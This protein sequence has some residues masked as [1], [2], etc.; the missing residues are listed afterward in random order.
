M[1]VPQPWGHIPAAAGAGGGHVGVSPRYTHCTMLGYSHN[2]K[3]FI[4][5]LVLS[6]LLVPANSG[7]TITSNNRQLARGFPV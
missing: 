4:P 2:F 7:I 6:L 1:E 5:L 3:I